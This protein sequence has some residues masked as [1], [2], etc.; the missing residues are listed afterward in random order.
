MSDSGPL[1]AFV[2]VAGW[3]AVAFLVFPVVLTAVASRG[4]AP[5]IEFPPKSW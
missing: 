1:R 2:S 5:F 4:G 3:L